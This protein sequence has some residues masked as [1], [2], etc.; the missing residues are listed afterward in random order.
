MKLTRET[1][2]RL[3]STRVVENDGAE[4]FGPFLARSGARI[5]I[6]FVNS[7]FR[8]RTCTAP[9]DGT[10]PV[11]C[12]QYYARRCL[13][14]CVSVLCGREEYLQIVRLARLFLKN[15]RREFELSALALIDASAEGLEFERA[16]A[17]RDMLA[18]AKAFWEH[19]RRRVWIDDAVDTVVVDR[20]ADSLTIFI[21]TT[22][23]ARTLGSWTCELQIFE[24]M[25]IRDILA[26]V[27]SEFY[28]VGGPRE[29]RVP[30][31]F[32]G[33]REVANELRTR[34][35]RPVNITVEGQVPE[36][37][38][39]LKALA[40]TR[41]DLDLNDLKPR[42]PP[43][44]ISRLLAKSFR[45]PH[46]PR[47]IHAF[48]AAH[49]SG[50]FSTAG[51][52]AWESGRLTAEEFRQG[53][54]EHTSEIETLKEFIAD[55]YG[56][57]DTKFPDLILVDGGKAHVNAAV[58]ALG[59]VSNI[60]VIGAV[61]PPGRHSEIAHFITGD[62]LKVEFDPSNPAMLVLKILRDEAHALANEA[63][64]R[65]RD[66]A[67]FYELAAMLPSLTERERKLLTSRLGTVRQILAADSNVVSSMIG[68]ERAAL[69]LQDIAVQRSD[70]V[71]K[72]LPPLI[73]IRY[74]DVNGEAEDL[75]PI[76]ASSRAR[77]G[78]DQ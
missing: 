22:R 32:S 55:G 61:K 67:H 26:R 70:T 4:Y 56:S 44:R 46:R 73:P 64:R 71:K 33:R 2:P 65:V 68:A 17:V 23:R 76:N 25:D 10:F 12:T 13:A 1:F 77:P 66:M 49:I 40:R 78:P 7:T 52:S 51:M 50:T 60:P 38:T 72:L 57:A 59:P 29:I 42:V 63:H 14:P 11:P 48:D 21:I 62:G 45:L 58:K 47:L 27:I 28:Q 31:E 43:E 30:F 18:R 34:F 9:I 37:V 41:L 15:D 75:R 20:E 16:A 54:S 36:R 39:A 24:E 6:D 3:L 8:L 74:D 69:F 19:P 53:T 35:G 5:L